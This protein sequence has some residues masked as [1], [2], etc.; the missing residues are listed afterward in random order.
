MTAPHHPSLFKRVLASMLVL[1]IGLG[2]LATPAYAALTPLADQPLNV[3][4]ASKPN[5]VLTVDDSTSM[6]FDFLPD[7]V[8]NAYCRDGSG[9]MAAICGQ[10]GMAN[11]FSLFGYGKFMSPGYISQQWKIPYASYS[12]GYDAS[13]PGAGCDLSGFPPRC[14][15]GVDPTSGNSVPPGIERYPTTS[16]V[17]G[18]LYE[19]W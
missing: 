18:Q 9:K 16:P 7:Y 12:A 11:D 1:L 14:S 2:P 8:V 3:K 17:G 13:G 5:I 4:N 15:G 6:L 19:Y 10:G